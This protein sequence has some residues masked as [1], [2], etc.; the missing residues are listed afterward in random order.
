MRQYFAGQ[1]VDVPWANK[2]LTRVRA[3]TAAGRRFARVRVVTTPVTEYTRFGL[4]FAQHTVGAGEDIRYLDREQAADLPN[5]D[6]WM[7]DSRVLT[8]MHFADDDGRLTGLEIV[9]DPAEIVQHNYWR[10]AAQHHAVPWD[11]FATQQNVERLERSPG[12]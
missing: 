6:Y 8:R 4:W 5:H 3:A 7:F 12:A 1:P 10:D 2:W 9:E 11:E